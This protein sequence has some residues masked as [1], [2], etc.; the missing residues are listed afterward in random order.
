VGPTN[1]GEQAFWDAAFCAYVD[2]Q[3]PDEAKAAAFA[4]RALEVRRKV[5]SR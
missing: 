1:A 5:A 4:T 2:S 3:G